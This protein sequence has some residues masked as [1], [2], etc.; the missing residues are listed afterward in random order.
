MIGRVCEWLGLSWKPGHTGLAPSSL[1][2]HG[3]GAAASPIARIPAAPGNSDL[4]FEWD[5]PIE[6]A[7][8]HLERLG[9]EIEVEPSERSGA[10]RA[11]EQRLL[12]RSRRKSLGVHLLHGLKSPK[13]PNS[14]SV[15]SARAPFQGRVPLSIRRVPRRVYR[16]TIATRFGWFDC[17]ERRPLLRDSGAVHT[18]AHSRSEPRDMGRL[19]SNGSR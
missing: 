17:W 18:L 4:C 11:R 7:V 8:E 12:S 13:A 3:P 5:G 14:S 19:I 15:A 1:N 2:V 9:V 6:G 16:S 10:R